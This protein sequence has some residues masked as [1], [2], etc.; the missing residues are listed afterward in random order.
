MSSQ[1]L[2]YTLEEAFAKLCRA[3]EKV[4]C[5]LLA[6]VLITQAQLSHGNDEIENPLEYE[7]NILLANIF[8][9]VMVNEW[10]F[11]VFTSLKL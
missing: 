4:T 3:S 9:R 11:L 2:P 7:S 10:S 1:I 8:S 5:I 6:R